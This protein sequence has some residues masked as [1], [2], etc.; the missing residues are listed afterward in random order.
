MINKFFCATILIK[1]FLFVK[2]KRVIFGTN[3]PILQH[4]PDYPCK[5]FA[6]PLIFSAGYTIDP[7]YMEEKIQNCIFVEKMGL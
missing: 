4:I 1:S 5:K 6:F 3:V 7:E 2:T